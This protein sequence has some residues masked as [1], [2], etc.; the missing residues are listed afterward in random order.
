MNVSK[1]QINNPA[2]N[3][4][5]GCDVGAAMC[6]FVR[7]GVEYF[8]WEWQSFDLKIGSCETADINHSIYCRVCLTEFPP[9]MKGT[10]G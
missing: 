3:A 2:Q 7:P 1:K 10:T 5:H 9:F 4:L 6:G 8:I